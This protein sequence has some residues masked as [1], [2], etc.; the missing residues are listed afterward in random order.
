[1]IH[2]IDSESRHFNYL[3]PLVFPFIVK[4]IEPLR[5]TRAQ[6][7][8]VMVLAAISTKAWLSIRGKFHDNTFM[9]PD[10]L[11]TMHPGRSWATMYLPHRGQPRWRHY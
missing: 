8:L 10:Q 9:F 11:Y 1:V 7:G 2:S 6:Y 5:W 4:A 3:I